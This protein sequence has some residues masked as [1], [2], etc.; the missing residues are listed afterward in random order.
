MAGRAAP[1]LQRKIATLV[2]VGA[3]VVTLLAGVVVVTSIWA[4]DQGRI[5]D[6]AELLLFDQI[7]LVDVVDGDV[8]LAP[9]GDGAFAIAID[10]DTVVAVSGDAFNDVVAGTIIDDAAAYPDPTGEFI[11]VAEIEID[12][13]PWATAYT[14]CFDSD[15]C[16]TIGVGI[17]VPSWWSYV[18]AR[19]LWILLAAVAVAVAASVSAAWLVTRSLRPVEAMRRELAATTATDLTRRVPVT[20]SGDELEALAVTLNATLDRLESAVAANRRFVADAAHELR[21]PL[22]GVRAAVELRTGPDTDDILYDA[23]GELDRA[24]ALVDDLLFLA[25]GQQPGT[26]IGDVPFDRVVADEIEALGARRSDMEVTAT[27]EPVTVA[28]DGARLARVVRNL[29]ENAARYGQG[30]IDVTVSVRDGE[31]VL[32]VDDDGSGV[33]VADR[34]RV[35]ERFVRLDESRSRATGGSGLG[36]AIVAEIVADGSG[37]VTVVDASGGGARFEVRLPAVG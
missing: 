23:L 36:L 37:T 9:I 31:A 12:G 1:S 19:S 17:Q 26:A 15:V 11:S 33:P 20:E 6:S 32:W 21:S 34:E 30:R 29:L 13:S 24:S 18:A 25:R 2:G 4:A 27:L 5:F 22:T 10:G 14:S 35:F 28:G 3:A 8:V 7:E 16:T